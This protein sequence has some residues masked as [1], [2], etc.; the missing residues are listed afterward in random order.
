MGWFS[1]ASSPP[2]PKASDGGSIA[3]DRSSRE[4]CYIAR[5]R[6]FNC[7]NQNNIIDAI[8]D[9]KSARSSCGKE[10][11]EFESACSKTWAK[12]FKE[13]RVMEYRR[14]Q[15]IEKIKR[16]DAEM[17]AREADRKGGKI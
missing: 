12:Y 6:F 2:P 14:D 3:P 10:I 15:T 5:D 16:D 8:K 4:Q 1:S 13:K 9:D 17:A 11:E 7:L